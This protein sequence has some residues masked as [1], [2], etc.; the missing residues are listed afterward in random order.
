MDPGDVHSTAK[1]KR[2]RQD[3]AIAL[4]TTTEKQKKSALPDQD[5]A[6]SFVQENPKLDGTSAYTRYEQYK[7]A[8]SISEAL[9]LS[10]I[11]RDI[12]N[13]WSKGFMYVSR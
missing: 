12:A 5:D 2:K 13:D 1:A 8:K 10:A 11:H 6:V 3:Q 7:A 9:I 4:A